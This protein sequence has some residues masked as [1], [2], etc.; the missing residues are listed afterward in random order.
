M[1]A[2]TFLFLLTA[3]S[4]SAGELPQLTEKPYLGQYV[5]LDTR[6]FRFVVKRGGEA[7][8]TPSKKGGDFINDRYSIKLVPL[9]EEVLPDGKVVGK[10]VPETGWEAV[11][12]AAENPKK[13]TYRGTSSGGATFEVNIEI[14][15][16]KIAAGGRLLEK[17][18][19]KNPRFVI[20]AQVPNVYQYDRDA[21]KRLEKSKKD[22]IDLVRADGKKLKLDVNTPLDAEGKETNGPGIAQARIEMAGYAGH[23]IELSS[24][25]NGIFEFW[26]KGEAALYEGFTLGWKHDAAKDPEGKGRL[27]VELK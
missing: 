14:D 18:S 8:I 22:R 13:V 23:K 27:T 12:P 10:F 5:G 26:N 6:D 7:L 3:S 21:E 25:P 20:R 24:G 15:G 19:L 11:T 9:I 1:K 16:G 4:L 2:R 17:G